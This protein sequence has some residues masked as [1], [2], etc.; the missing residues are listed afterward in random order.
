M[1]TGKQMV[2]IVR[3][4]YPTEDVYEICKSE[5]IAI[6]KTEM[7]ENRFGIYLPVDKLCRLIVLEVGMAP[8][9][10]QEV[11]AYELYYHFTPAKTDHV[12]P[13]KRR[14]LRYFPY[15]LGKWQAHSFASLL[16]CPDVSKCRSVREIM[17]E[18]SCTEKVAEHRWRVEEAAMKYGGS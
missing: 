7:E 15:L 2:K 10:E 13:A 3:E 8:E 14:L 12:D 9:V 1:K 4:K 11:L 17:E 5:G 6:V 18:Y 16:L